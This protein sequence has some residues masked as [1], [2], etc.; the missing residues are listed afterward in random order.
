MKRRFVAPSGALLVLTWAACAAPQ[1]DAET[2]TDTMDAAA[3]APTA[4]AQ[5]LACVQQR[6]DMD[7]ALSPYDSVVVPLGDANAQICYSKPSA[8]GRMVFDSLVP[9]GQIWRT[10]ANEP[11]IIHTP[12]PLS[13]AGIEVPPGSYSLYTVPARGD[14]WQV[15]VNRSISQWGHEG[16]YTGE[17]EAQEVGRAPVP[18]TSTTETVEQFTIRA[19]P[20]G[21]NAATVIL[22]WV[23]TRVAIPVSTE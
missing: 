22:E 16:E 9:Y 12:V 11:T 13:I 1:S 2:G 8:R 21:A 14:E 10:G 3:A 19:E 6:P 4:L 18:A 17:V 15:V 7:R 5:E 20:A 23:D